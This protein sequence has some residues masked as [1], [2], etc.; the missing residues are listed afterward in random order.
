MSRSMYPLLVERSFVSCSLIMWSWLT[1]CSATADLSC[2]ASLI[3]L[4]CFLIW[5]W[6][7][8]PLCPDTSHISYPHQPRAS[9]WVFA[10]H[11]LLCNR[12]HPYPVTLLSTGSDHFRTKPFSL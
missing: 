6:M 7:N 5:V 11:Y 3:R 8:R 4:L 1:L 12:T 10:L 2:C 9:M